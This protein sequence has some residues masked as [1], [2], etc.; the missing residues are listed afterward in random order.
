MSHSKVPIFSWLWWLHNHKPS[1]CE[2][3][4]RNSLVVGVQ[5][6]VPSGLGVYPEFQ[7]K[8]MDQEWV[9]KFKSGLELGLG[10]VSGRTEDRM[11]ET[12]KQEMRIKKESKS[13]WGKKQVEV[14]V[15]T[16]KL[17]DLQEW[18]KVIRKNLAFEVDFLRNMTFVITACLIQ[19]VIVTFAFTLHRVFST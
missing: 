4:S 13:W 1:S 12:M 5:Q 15:K 2:S 6:Q 3:Y 17:Q 16:R 7:G 8:V 10:F 14:A 11:V 19:Y 18:G 9:G